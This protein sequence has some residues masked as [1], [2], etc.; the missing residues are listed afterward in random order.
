MS[1][2]ARA[3]NS[4]LP[5]AARRQR[6]I[7]APSV[8]R[9]ALVN[10]ARKTGVKVTVIERPHD[11]CAFCGSRLV[12][13]DRAALWWKCGVCG[14]VFDQD[15]HYCRLLFVSSRDDRD[16]RGDEVDE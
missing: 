1:D 3:K 10:F 15:E 12:P 6:F 5:P 7:A 2:T 14:C 16:V 13:A 8:F 9:L 11:T 4:E